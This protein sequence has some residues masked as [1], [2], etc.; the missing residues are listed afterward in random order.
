MPRHPAQP[1]MKDRNLLF[2]DTETGGLSPACRDILEVACVLTDP[3]GQ[4]VIEEWDAKILATRPVDE[5]AAE[6]NGYDPVK[7]AAEAMPLSE[8]MVKVLSMARD[9]VMCCHNAPF[10]K[11]F[12]DA[13][14]ALCRQRWTGSY[15]TLCTMSLA[16]PLL[17][18]GLVDNVKLTTLTRYFGIPHADAHRAMSDARACRDVFVKLDTIYAP[19]VEAHR[20][21]IS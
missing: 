12:L 5:K 2:L 8:A 3:S 21:A 10:D 7:W 6:I 17:R 16:M 9:A 1:A 4:T 20:L 18:A 13:A 11:G 15:H 19:A 14:L